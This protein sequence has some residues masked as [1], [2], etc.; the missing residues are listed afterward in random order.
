[1]EY[2]GE[3]RRVRMVERV[4]GMG[5]GGRGGEGRGGEGRGGYLLWR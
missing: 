3:R 2:S 5:D 4:K 1:M